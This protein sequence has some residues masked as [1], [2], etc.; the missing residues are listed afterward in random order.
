VSGRPS[1]STACREIALRRTIQRVGQWG[2]GESFQPFHF[3]I[4]LYA[5]RW[6][7][8]TAKAP[9]GAALTNPNAIDQK[10]M[11]FMWFREESVYNESLRADG[12][13]S[14]GLLQ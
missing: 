11:L 5:R 2:L 12:H 8:H 13:A 4:R 1:D 6:M 3:G 9:T 7:T 14:I 10:S